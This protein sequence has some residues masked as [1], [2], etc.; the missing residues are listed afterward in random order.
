MT[1]VPVA[2]ATLLYD[3]CME[4]AR[5]LWWSWNPEVITLFRDIDPH[6]WRQLDHNPIALL[7]EKTP[8][9]LESIA[10]E[11]ALH[12]RILYAWWLLKEYESNKPEWARMHA[13]VLSARPVAY[14]SL[15][16]GIHE[17]LPIY[18][19]GLGVLAGDHIKSAS[20]LGVPLV[21]I[22]L[23]YSQGYFKQHLDATGW[24]KEE[25]IDTNVDDL[26]LTLA[27]DKSG[28]PIQIEIATNTGTLRAKVRQMKVG[29]VLL[30]LLDTDVEGN[31]PEDR[32][33][34]ARLYGGDNRIR[35]RQEMV[36][37]I[38]GVRALTA[39]GITPSVWHL[40]EGHCVF[41]TLELVRQRIVNQGM[42]FEDACTRVAEHTVFTT[43]TPVPAGHD[44]FHVSLIREHLEPMC[45]ELGISVERLMEM[46]RDPYDPN[47]DPDHQFCSTVL[48]LKMS[49]HVN[50]VSAL[51]GRVSR[52]MWK[53][54]WPNREEHEIPIG[55]ITNGVHL[56]S[57][58][59]TSMAVLFDR[60]FPR[61]WMNRIGE[62][63]LWQ[64]VYRI[65]PEVLW[66]AHQLLKSELVTFV[67]RRLARQAR[68]RGESD[69]AI[70]ATQNV[71][72]T[73]AL[74]IGF[75][76]RFATYK[77]ATMIF[78]D[79]ERLLKIIGAEDR[80]VQLIF[81]GKAHP[82]D[83]PGKEFI[84]AISNMRRDPRLADRVFFIEDYDINV[85]RH[86][87]QGVD[88]WLNN[89]RR[90]LEA[91]G[92]SGQKALLNGALNLSI[93]D[94]WWA[95]AYNGENGFAIGIGEGH[96]DEH[97]QFQHD[98]ESLYKVL[99]DDV[100]PMYFDKDSHGMPRR[101]VQYMMNSIASLAWRFSAERMIA[102]YVRQAYLPAAGGV[103]CE[104]K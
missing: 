1:T 83:R 8:E 6:R 47:G 36:A 46:G 60:Y 29:R 33:L 104:A 66:E 96:V 32:Q 34:T 55:H 91:S 41:A 82:A 86:M 89:P 102:D 35:L 10:T 26:P 76:R 99:E 95:E 87:V 42:R 61:N 72:R 68:Y 73:D 77:R 97:I 38:G 62:P 50:A 57:W 81:A 51:H 79:P 17:S 18:S 78:S 7:K 24:Q 84:Q 65:E 40:N 37:G 12:S 5:N 11:H 45:R 31:S 48:G 67:R 71:L 2:G 14:F 3:K 13:G 90:P 59:A 27:C 28:N 39:M 20:N 98:A 69:D 25:Y 52:R 100:V 23:F 93:L 16:F 19:G 4:I 43:H 44:R 101:W 56:A 53:H 85:A 75:A 88:V 30:L 54:L 49:R 103:S 94:G 64:D 74:T 92:T 58:C 22:G 80:P 63:E 9:Q 15:E 21:A 70:A